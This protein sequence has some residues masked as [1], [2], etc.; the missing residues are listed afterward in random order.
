MGPIRRRT[1]A[2][3]WG[4]ATWLLPSAGHAAISSEEL[5]ALAGQRLT[6]DRTGA[7]MAVAVVE[8]QSVATA[9]VCADPKDRGRI[10]ERSAFE[11]GSISK[12]FT[13]ALLADQIAAGRMSLDD[14]LSRYLPEGTKVPGFEGRTITLRHLVTH[15]SGLPAL[16]PR[17][18]IRN[19][20]NPYAVLTE[21]QLFDSL[22][23]VTLTQAPGSEW[24]YSNFAVMLLSQALSRSYRKDFETAVR[25]RL[26]TPL[27]MTA[28]FVSTP[29]AGV[30][31]A[32]GHV[33]FPSR[34]GTKA[35]PWDFPVNMAG[36]GGF[37]STLPDMVRY[38]QANLGQ[39]GVGT[40]SATA[41]ART[42]EQLTHIGNV[43]MG[44][45]WVISS[46]FDQTIHLHEGHTGGFSSFL[47]FDKQRKRGVVVLSDTS[48]N[49]LGGLSDLGLHLMDARVPLARPRL[50]TQAEPALLDALA[51]DYRMD[52]G[53]EITLRRRDTVLEMQVQGQKAYPLGHDSSG[54]FFPLAIDAVLRPQPQAGGYR[55]AW[56]QG[57]SSVVARRT[58]AVRRVL[59][60]LRTDELMAYT[61]QY[62]VRDD[63]NLRVFVL[64]GRLWGQA[65]E[66]GAFPLERVMD[67]VFFAAQPEIELKFERQQGQLSALVLRQGGVDTRVPMPGAGTGAASASAPSAGPL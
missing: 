34:I 60:P 2:L 55:I 40:A 51:G 67:D 42:H 26:F 14:P 39:R 53:T 66:Q 59:A 63:M 37:R 20:R 64:G 50:L 10:D 9:Y 11:I 27:G 22:A 15:T 5:A 7:C 23:E 54:D 4:C 56:L 28:S 32:D 44:M 38:L 65:G 35:S 17:M 36:V 31:V 62:R 49:T 19:A 24:G 57:G 29:P 41:L 6:G 8:A 58:D 18:V 45:G 48:F 25:E 1:L 52:N 13:A 12:T 30:R 16:P 46:L 33:V 3:L 47:A 21:K 61:G 43:R